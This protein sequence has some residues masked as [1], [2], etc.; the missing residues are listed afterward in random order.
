MKK[1]KENFRLREK[2]KGAEPIMDVIEVSVA[3]TQ[4]AWGSSGG[5]GVQGGWG[6]RSNDQTSIFWKTF[7]QKFNFP[8]FQF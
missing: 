6:V 4:L 7:N 3:E 2:Q 1:E 5:V 8:N